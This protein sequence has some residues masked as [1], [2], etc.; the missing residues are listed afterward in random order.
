MSNIS[1]IGGYPLGYKFY[2][3]GDP[4]KRYGE[5]VDPQGVPIGST[6]RFLSHKAIV[7]DHNQ[8]NQYDYGIDQW[9]RVK[10]PTSTK[11]ELKALE[12]SLGKKILNTLW[13]SLGGALLGSLVGIVPSAIALKSGAEDGDPNAGK[14]SMMVLGI[15][16]IGG[17]LIGGTVSYMDMK[18]EPQRTFNADMHS[19][20]PTFVPPLE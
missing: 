12:P 15:T 8:N 14:K 20:L 9:M 13:G 7:V 16:I 3:E 19:K 18:K 2:I 10:K 6:G 5:V 17:A 1:A 11:E 4:H